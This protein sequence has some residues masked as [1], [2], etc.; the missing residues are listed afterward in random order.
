MKEL[1]VAEPEIE[2]APF[3]ERAEQENNRRGKK[4]G[5]VSALK[6]NNTFGYLIV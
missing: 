3:L 5:R 4:K 6:E 1:R 2:S